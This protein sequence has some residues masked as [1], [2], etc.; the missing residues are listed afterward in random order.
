MQ[1]IRKFYGVQQQWTIKI[2]LY[3]IVYIKKPSPEKRIAIETK[4]TNG[5]KNPTGQSRQW[6]SLTSI[7]DHDES[8]PQLRYPWVDHSGL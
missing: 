1:A 8:V 3:H 2:S 5:T 4:W 7:E 6:T